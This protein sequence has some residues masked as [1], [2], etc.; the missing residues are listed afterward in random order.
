MK[1]IV[2]TEFLEMV[3]VKFSA[4]MAD[5]ILNDANPASGGAYTAVGIYDHQELVDMVVS[6][7][8]HSG[9]PVP[10][11]IK[12]FG[13]HLFTVFS[14]NYHMFFENVPDAFSFLYGIDDVIHAEVI[15]LYPDAKLPKFQCEREGDTLFMTYTSDRHL[16][17]LAEGLILGS[18]EYFGEEITLKRD[19]LDENSTLFTLTKH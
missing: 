6:L 12:T 18:A 16:A 14:R 17:D 1:G 10:D 4:D 11:L 7:S 2:F 19:E 5:D 13:K 8:E 15:K 3:E 9:I